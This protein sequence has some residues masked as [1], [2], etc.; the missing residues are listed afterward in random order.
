MAR[1]QLETS[2]ILFTDTLRERK[3][4]R[5]AA[6]NIKELRA[7]IQNHSLNLDQLMWLYSYH[8]TTTSLVSGAKTI[9]GLRTRVKFL[10]HHISHHDDPEKEPKHN[11][12]GIVMFTHWA[13]ASNRTRIYFIDT[14][15]HF[16]YPVMQTDYLSLQ[17]IAAYTIRDLVRFEQKKAEPERRAAEATGT[18][19]T[20]V[21]YTRMHKIAHF[22]MVVCEVLHANMQTMEYIVACRE[23]FM[24]QRAE[25]MLMI[26]TDS[27]ATVNKIH[28]QLRTSAHVIF[29][30]HGW[31]SSYLGGLQNEIQLVS[32]VVSQDEA[33]ASVA[34]ARA[35]KSDNEIMKTT[36]FIALVFLPP[37]FISA[38]SSTS[39]FSFSNDERGW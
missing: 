26:E 7:E 33:R 2:Q 36:S 12:E 39:F 13:Q 19:R 16:M 29:S 15:A 5:K 10:T 37:T 35:T 22:A 18:A 8:H 25:R 6:Y 24:R 4:G 34:I 38:N 17:R 1:Y 3:S 30:T 31:C 9:L 14:D 28:Q 32:N 21:G 27:A 20:R 23:D 11:W